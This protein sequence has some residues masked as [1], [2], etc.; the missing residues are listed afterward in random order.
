MLNSSYSYKNS[1]YKA[2]LVD[3]LVT[4]L[5]DEAEYGHRK[6]IRLNGDTVEWSD[7]TSE[8]LDEFIERRADQIT[9]NDNGATPSR[10][11]TDDAKRFY[12]ANIEDDN[13][14]RDYFMQWIDDLELTDKVASAYIEGNY[15][16]LDVLATIWTLETNAERITAEAIEQLNQ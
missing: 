5:K 8:S 9:G 11:Y 1:N 10:I 3:N 16:T 4:M 2:D 6:P 7:G 14:N 12:R 13:D 15:N